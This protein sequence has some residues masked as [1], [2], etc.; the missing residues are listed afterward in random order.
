MVIYPQLASQSKC[1]ILVVSYMRS[2]SEAALK[3][4]S[5]TVSDKSS[6]AFIMDR[7]FPVKSFTYK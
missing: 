2:N 7:T 6:N 1:I 3:V 4:C 5:S